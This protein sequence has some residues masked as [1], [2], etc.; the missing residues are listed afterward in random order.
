MTRTLFLDVFYSRPIL[1]SIIKEYIERVADAKNALKEA[2]EKNVR[3]QERKI[4]KDNL[5]LLERKLA[6]SKQKLEI[7]KQYFS[8]LSSSLSSASFFD[9][10]NFI[11]TCRIFP[12]FIGVIIYKV[13]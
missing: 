2:I 12:S 13:H 11:D 1:I 10:Q 3:K 7:H 4:L 5:K 9:F 6:E 8:Y